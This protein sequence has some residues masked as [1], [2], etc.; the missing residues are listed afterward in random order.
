MATLDILRYAERLASKLLLRCGRALVK[1]GSELATAA[2]TDSCVASFTQVSVQA[3]DRFFDLPKPIQVFISFFAAVLA[4]LCFVFGMPWLASNVI[5]RYPILPPVP[6]PSVSPT[7]DEEYGRQFPESEKKPLLV[8]M[9]NAEH[10][11]TTIAAYSPSTGDVLGLVPA[12]DLMTVKSKVEKARWAQKRWSETSFQQRS[13]VMNVL[14]AYILDEKDDLAAMCLVDTGKTLLDACLGEILPTLEKLRWIVSE[15]AK[16]LAPEKRS[17]GPLTAHKHASVEFRPL[18]VVGAIAPWNYPLHNLLNPAISSLFAGNAVVIKPSEHTVYSSVYFARIVRRALSLCGH[19][20][21]LLQIL[22][23]GPDIG[24]ALVEADIDKLFFTGSTFVG[25]KVAQAAASRLLP[26]VLEL[27][28][29]D[30][31][32]ICDDAPI[33]HA[34]DI[35]LRGV[36]QNAG[37]N[38]IGIERVFVHSSVKQEVVSRFVSCVRKMRLGTDV[39]ALTLCEAALTHIQEL[40]DDAVSN[41]AKVLVGGKRGSCEGIYENGYFY[42]PTVL[43][44]I[45]PSMRIAKEEVFGPVLSVI[46]WSNDEELIEM[47]NDC[48]FGLGSSIFTPDSR[49]ANK[50]MNRLRVGMCNVNDFAANYLCQSMP[51]GGTRDSGIDKFAGIEGLRGCCLSQSVTRDRF[52]GIKTVIPRNLKYPVSKNAFALCSAMNNL[53]YSSGLLSRIDSLRD[54]VFML[55]FKTWHPHDTFEASPLR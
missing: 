26:V 17:T 6:L 39:G 41:G 29:K 27:G 31:F 32:I 30:P 45:R 21:E 1:A 14:K 7:I 8:S 34:V 25:R 9:D 2:V 55:L 20:P 48:P 51:F 15:G 54:I 36:F 23:G 19:S 16:A 53:F 3:S 35:C 33:E 37:Q 10:R 47:V 13:V 5:W 24:A 22:V 49:R 28:G 52:P 43:D 11:E 4:V 38:C 46:D 40:V 18:G 12:D 44:G 42:Q 50:I